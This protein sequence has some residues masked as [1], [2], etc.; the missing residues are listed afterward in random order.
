MMLHS[1]QTVFVFFLI[2]RTE[3]FKTNPLHISPFSTRSPANLRMQ[4]EIG[5]SAILPSKPIQVATISNMTQILDGYVEYGINEQG[6]CGQASQD[7]EKSMRI[8]CQRCLY[9]SWD[10]LLV[11]RRCLF[12]NRFL[13]KCRYYA[14]QIR[15]QM[16]GLHLL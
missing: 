14:F 5:L 11:C 15:K 7:S 6:Y 10:I 13:L 9:L 8:A 4:Y 2:S 1:I 16:K 12:L 3:I